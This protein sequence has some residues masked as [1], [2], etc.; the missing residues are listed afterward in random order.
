MAD[1]DLLLKKMDDA[2]CREESIA[3]QRRMV[4]VFEMILDRLDS[5]E[6]GLIRLEEK[7]K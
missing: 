1:Y 5:L 3:F 6:K 2:A 4:D 7:V